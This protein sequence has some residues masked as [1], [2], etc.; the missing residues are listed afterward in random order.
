[1]HDE[2]I[3]NRVYQVVVNPQEQYSIW[4]LSLDLP[5][6]WRAIAEQG[7]KDECLARI[8][9]LWTDQRPLDVRQRAG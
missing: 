5:A 1:M 6:G 4:P 8:G 7:S 2:D 3:D 9:V